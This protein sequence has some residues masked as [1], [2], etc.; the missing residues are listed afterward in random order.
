MSP[1]HAFAKPLLGFWRCLCRKRPT[2]CR[3]LGEVRCALF[4][5]D[6]EPIEIQ[7]ALIAA[8]CGLWI[9][10]FGYYPEPI[11]SEI[12]R[13]LTALLPDW[14]WAITF[15]L[16]GISQSLALWKGQLAW[17]AAS[18]MLSFGVWSFMAALLIVNVAPGPA[19]VIIP[20]VALSE[21]WV[22]LR[23]TTRWDAALHD[24]HNAKTV[25]CAESRV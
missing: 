12:Y 4:Q 20:I 18:A 6:P 5:Y 19:T 13:L 10:Y 11:K 15:V 7:T 14:S 22:Y 16:L 17:R 23:L 25:E 3:S 8:A 2:L 21:G 9:S 24:S 1:F